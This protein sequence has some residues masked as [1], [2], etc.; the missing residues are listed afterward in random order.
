ME[1]ILEN[2]PIFKIFIPKIKEL[3]KYILYLKNTNIIYV[4]TIEGDEY[5]QCEWCK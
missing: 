4:T 2:T 1:H 3:K 5:Y